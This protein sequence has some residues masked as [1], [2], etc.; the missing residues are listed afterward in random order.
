[1]SKVAERVAIAEELLA[2]GIIKT[3][4]EYLNLINGEDPKI[5]VKK[6]DFKAEIDK[7]LSE[8]IKE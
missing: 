1:M 6:R 5:T 7:I 3:S 8:E 4:E 2:A